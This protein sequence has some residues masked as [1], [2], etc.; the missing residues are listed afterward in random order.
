MERS[1]NKKDRPI[2]C[3]LET[4]SAGKRNPS[5]NRDT[6]HSVLSHTARLRGRE[7]GTHLKDTIEGVSSPTKQ[8]LNFEQKCRVGV[9]GRRE[10]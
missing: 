9:R 3:K 10:C 4:R 6:I 2:P 5:T 8:N 1:S 7:K